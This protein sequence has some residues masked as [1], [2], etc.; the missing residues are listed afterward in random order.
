MLTLGGTT[1]VN[2]LKST[3]LAADPTS[4]DKEGEPQLTASPLDYHLFRQEITSKYPAYNP[5][6]ALFPLEPDNNS[7]LPPFSESSSRSA[8][9]TQLSSVVGPANI[10]GSGTSIM[11][12]PVHIATPVP[13]PPPSPAGPGGKGIKK[14]N[15]QTNQMF[16]FL[17][18]PL[19][20]SSNDLG[21]KGSTE[22]QDVLVGRKWQGSDIP[23]SILEA[24]DLFAKR[25]RAT[26]TM[27]QLWGE[28]VLFMKYERGY[29]SLDS[30]EAL[31]TTENGS[32]KTTLE[33]KADDREELNDDARRKLEVVEDFYVCIIR[34]N[35]TFR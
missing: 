15:Y 3:F 12:Q 35:L 28:R 27:K 24:T 9:S 18:P 30:V 4:A 16:P 10:P 8:S 2:D 23:A 17:Y 34:R 22:L 33:S 20:S 7:M 1:E 14:Q 6:P 19:D 31:A 13:S 32:T 29:G 5:P 11:H 21:G 26:R 25:M